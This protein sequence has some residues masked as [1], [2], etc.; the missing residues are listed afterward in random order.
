MFLALSSARPRRP[1]SASTAMTGGAVLL[2]SL[3][4]TTPASALD[5]ARASTASEKA[6]CADPVALAE[7]WVDHLDLW[8]TRFAGDLR[9]N[10]QISLYRA[11]GER[12][13]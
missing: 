7:L 13:H 10:A 9:E 11:L 12:V 4:A 3:S 1:A 2:A 5:C 6:I 8:A